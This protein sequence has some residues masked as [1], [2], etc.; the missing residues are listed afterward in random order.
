MTHIAPYNFGLDKNG[1]NYVPLSPLSFI[2]RAALVYPNRIAVIHGEWQ[3]TWKECYDRCRRLASALKKRGIG[4]GD[5]VA[6]TA[7]NVP[8]MYEA[9]FAV[10]MI[11]AVLNTLNTRLDAEAIGFMLQ[12]GEAK[13]VITDREYSAI[14]EHALPMIEERPLVVD[15]DDPEHQGGKLLG[16]KDYEAFL[17]GA[18]A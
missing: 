17:L 11:G 14:M 6:L 8:A 2:E 9:H 10:P 1:A 4:V 7:A 13:V 3:I 5:T 16:E 15:I 18:S 12:H